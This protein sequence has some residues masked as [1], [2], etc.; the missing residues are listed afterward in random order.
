MS[1]IGINNI[2]E[3]PLSTAGRPRGCRAG[4]REQQRRRSQ[5]AT[6]SETPIEQQRRC[7][8]PSADPEAPIR[9]KARSK[10]P[11][12]A[13]AAVRGGGDNLASISVTL[14]DGGRD[15]ATIGTHRALP[16][17]ESAN[18]PQLHVRRSL[19]FCDVMELVGAVYDAARTRIIGEITLFGQ[20]ATGRMPMGSR[21][22]QKNRSTTAR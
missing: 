4:R 3:E 11:K 7:P 2:N 18:M 14:S 13:V 10:E 21:Y 9:K 22:Q 15:V 16:A 20:P 5:S 6:A 8:Q 1:F 12:P 17:C 19:L